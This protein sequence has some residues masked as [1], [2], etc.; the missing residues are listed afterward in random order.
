MDESAP[1]RA[2]RF[3][4]PCKAC[5]GVP[6]HV[7][8]RAS[9]AH[10]DVAGGPRLS[11]AAAPSSNPAATQQ[12]RPDKHGQRARQT[13]SRRRR[14]AAEQLEDEVPVAVARLDGDETAPGR[15]Q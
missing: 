10:M 7:S 1:V 2:V 8:G 9:T 6:I 13:K 12:L 11:A 4:G 5:E 3:P 14:G 15:P